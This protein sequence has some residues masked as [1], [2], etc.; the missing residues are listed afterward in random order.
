MNS[1]IVGNYFLLFLLVLEVYILI[2]KGV[3]ISKKIVIRIVL[4]LFFLLLGFKAT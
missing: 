3:R 4:I 2:N 1:G